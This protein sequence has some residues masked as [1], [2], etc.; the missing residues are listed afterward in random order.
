MLDSA[1]QTGGELYVLR[2][3][4]EIEAE[5]RRLREFQSRADE[6]S[7]LIVST[8]LPWVDI[9]IRIEKLRQEAERLFP[10]K[11]ELFERIYDSRFERLWNQ[12]RSSREEAVHE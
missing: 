8:D 3:E 2:R 1:I 11:E 9:A 7:R 5:T 6:I 4:Y 12:W 10:G